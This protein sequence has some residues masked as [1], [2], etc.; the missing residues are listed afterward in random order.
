MFVT[1]IQ[2]SSLWNFCFLSVEFFQLLHGIFIRG[3]TPCTVTSRHFL[4]KFFHEQ[5]RG[6]DG[7]ALASDVT[8]VILPFPSCGPT[9]FP[10]L[11]CS[12]QDCEPFE[13]RQLSNLSSVHMDSKF[14]STCQ[15]FL[16]SFLAVIFSSQQG[17]AN[18]P[19]HFF[20]R[21]FR[22]H[23]QDLVFFCRVSGVRIHDALDKIETTQE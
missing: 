11:I 3:V 18:I 12:L 10:K 23:A 8:N 15:S 9:Y 21:F 20:T 4:R 6:L 22:D 7:D 13:P 17:S 1:K 19:R 14:L 5:G 2:T 16:K